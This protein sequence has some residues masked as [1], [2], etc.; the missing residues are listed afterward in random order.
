MLSLQW[1]TEEDTITEGSSWQWRRTTK[2]DPRH[3]VVIACQKIF[4]SC[5]D[6]TSCL[7]IDSQRHL[8]F[9]WE[10]EIRD[11]TSRFDE[12]GKGRFVVLVANF[13]T[14]WLPVDRID[15]GEQHVHLTAY[16]VHEVREG[17]Q[18][19]YVYV[20]TSWADEQSKRAKKD[21]EVLV[22]A[23]CC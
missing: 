13:K 17:D 11:D 7:S 22:I 10:G 3:E 19:R 14:F 5:E 12:R 16:V 9:R 15:S 2:L 18:I 20:H 6:A 8:P 4:P 21:N 23:A 1:P